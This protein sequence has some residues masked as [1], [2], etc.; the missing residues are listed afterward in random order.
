MSNDVAVVV[1]HLQGEIL[2]STFEVLGLAKSVAAAAGGQTLAVLPGWQADSLAGSLGVADEVILVE[3]EALAAY[4]PDAWKAALVPVLKEREPLVT[5]IPRSV[6]G[7]DIAAPLSAALG[8]P[9]VASAQSVS[10]EDGKVVVGS[11]LFA[12]KASVQSDFMGPGIVGTMTGALDPDAGRAD[13]SPT[14]TKIQADLDPTAIKAS[15]VGFVEPSGEDIDISAQDVLVS[16]GRGIERADNVEI[17]QELADALG[18]A[19]SASRPV[20]DQ[21]WLP[22]TRQVGKSGSKVKPRLYLALGISG[23]PEHVEGMKDA[24]LIIAVNTDP[25]APIFEVAHYGATEDMLDV[26]E[27]LQEKLEG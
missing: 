21:E 12:G 13:G 9:L 27:A 10:V 1:E 26:V 11:Q 16:V 3:H 6:M 19:L 20:V 22:R 8:W 7:Y 14:V 15:F 25:A 24:D 23:A 5:L 4:S 2:E 17:V 18:G